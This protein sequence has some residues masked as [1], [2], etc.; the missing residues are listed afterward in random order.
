LE[1]G[2]SIS[3]NIT[4]TVAMLHT[5]N[6]FG[7]KL[8]VLHVANYT[9]KE[10]PRLHIVYPSPPQSIA[11][12]SASA[13]GDLIALCPQ[14][15]L[16]VS[17][18]RLSQRQEIYRI[19]SLQLPVAPLIA[20]SFV[21]GGS[22]TLMTAHSGGYAVFWDLKRL[23]DNPNS[24]CS[25]SPDISW[26]D[27]G[28]RINPFG[29]TL[30]L[31]RATDKASAPILVRVGKESEVQVMVPAAKASTRFDRS[32]NDSR[33]L[34]IA[35]DGNSGVI[36]RYLHSFGLKPKSKKLSLPTKSHVVH[37]T[38]TAVS[39]IAL[40]VILQNLQLQVRVIN[41]SNRGGVQ[42]WCPAQDVL[43]IWG[44]AFGFNDEFL[45]VG[46][47][48]RSDGFDKYAVCILAKQK[49]GTGL[50]EVL[51]TAKWESAK[52]IKMAFGSGGRLIV[53]TADRGSGPTPSSY[54]TITFNVPSRTAEKVDPPITQSF[55][56]SAAVVPAMS[57]EGEIFYLGTGEEEGWIMR[58]IFDEM[59]RDESMTSGRLAWCPLS[60]RRIGSL[61]I[62]CA[63]N[64]GISTV[65]CMNKCFGIAVIKVQ[66]AI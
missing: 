25:V 23:A 44:L 32:H 14:D 48:L 40:A 63:S 19:N 38:V 47:Q 45:G 43:N 35:E 55:T 60:W 46:V 59:R 9:A 58:L 24:I 57:S 21:P 49:T 12:F 62:L 56:T 17:V 1:S 15:L 6:A 18:V 29:D 7:A 42:D 16:A 26:S 3:F 51:R 5:T 8:D 39:T 31:N 34:A 30:L 27:D 37:S 20:L 41:W 33:P 66:L 11:A 2:L 53:L 64:A 54:S 28:H 65:V 61:S 52:P 13:D 22:G 4:G 50:T 36:G 10:N